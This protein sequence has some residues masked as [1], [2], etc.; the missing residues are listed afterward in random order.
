MSCRIPIRLLAALK[1]RCGPR[2]DPKF[3]PLV[4]GENQTVAGGPPYA[5][6]SPMRT[7]YRRISISRI[8]AVQT[9]TASEINT[10]TA[11]Q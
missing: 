11:A 1:P 7:A 6:E 5:G 10:P 3:N 9:P 2:Y 8:Q 4:L